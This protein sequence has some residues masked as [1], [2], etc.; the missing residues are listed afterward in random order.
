MYEPLFKEFLLSRG[1]C[2]FNK[3][4]NCP[5][6]KEENKNMNENKENRATELEYLKWFRLNCDFGP[7][8]GDYIQALHEQFRKETG[9]ELPKGWDDEE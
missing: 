5:Y 4:V 7:G 6:D 1:F 3:C 2:C 8:E 9:K